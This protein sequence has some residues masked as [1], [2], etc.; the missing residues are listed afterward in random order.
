MLLRTLAALAAAALALPAAVAALPSDPQ[1]EAT[2][3]AEGAAVPTD[4]DG[5]PV[6]FTCPAYTKID[7][8]GGFTLPGLVPQD[9]GATFS[10]A[11]TLGSDGRLASRVGIAQAISTAPGAC[12]AF[13]Y[14]VRRGSTQPPQLT[15][16]AYFWQAFRLCTSCAGPYETGPV[17][18]FVVRAAANLAVRPPRRAYATYP[19]LVPLRL[20]G[21]PDGTVALLERRVGGA[22]RVV[23]RTP[24]LSGA[25]E[26]VA[27]LPVGQQRL[28]VRAAIGSDTVTSPEVVLRVRPAS[29]PRSTRAR[30]VGAYTGS[31]GGA[32]LRVVQGG[33]ELRDLRVRVTMLCPGLEPGQFTIQA[34][35]VLIARVRVQP[36]GRFYAARTRSGSTMS[37]RGTLGGRRVTAGRAT[38]GLGDCT[39]TQRFTAR[40]TGA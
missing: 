9:Y 7:V 26:A 16:G 11:P 32:R 27:V 6:A 33:R 2:A 24:A 22:W 25:G 35:V 21:V 36:D 12:A 14:D 13:M 23:A 3:P 40:R 8:G 4:P 18:R 37:V 29:A 20:T 1:I 38:L 30:D 10:T 31:P 28:R 39:G 19:T 34:G 5:I 17:R 15:P